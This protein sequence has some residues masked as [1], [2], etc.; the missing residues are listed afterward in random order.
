VLASVSENR[1]AV[2]RKLGAAD[3]SML[4]DVEA[5]R[6][7]ELDALIGAVR[8][9]GQRVGAETPNIDA[10]FRLAHLFGCVRGLYP[11]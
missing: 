7:L 8:E 6:P 2:T 1:H 3:T 10:V 9:I 4:Q 5:L 11:P